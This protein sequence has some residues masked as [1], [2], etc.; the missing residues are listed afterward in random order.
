MTKTE[1]I[2]TSYKDGQRISEARITVDKSDDIYTL[3]ALQRQYEG[4]LAAIAEAKAKGADTTAL[5]KDRDRI[6]ASLDEQQAIVDG[7]NQVN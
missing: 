7:Y 3:A 2:S 5:E 4:I 6:K 1:I